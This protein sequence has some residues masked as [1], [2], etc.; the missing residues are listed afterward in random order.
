M[1]S[2]DW[3]HKP[4]LVQVLGESLQSQRSVALR[5]SDQVSDGGCEGTGGSTGVD[6]GLANHQVSRGGNTDSSEGEEADLNR[7]AQ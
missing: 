6:V 5:S 4:V 1:L 2:I 7:E 3:A